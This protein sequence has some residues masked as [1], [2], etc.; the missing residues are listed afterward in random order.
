ML[1][2]FCL[3]QPARMM[4]LLRNQAHYAVGITSKDAVLTVIFLTITS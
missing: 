2:R 4:N 1:W 3:N